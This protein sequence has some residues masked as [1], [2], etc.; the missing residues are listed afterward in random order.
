MNR[1]ATA[2][3][4]G[5]C[6]P[7]IACHPPLPTRI[8]VLGDVP[9]VIVQTLDTRI[10]NNYNVGLEGA[11]WSQQRVTEIHPCAAPQVS[12]QY[13]GNWDSDAGN[14]QMQV[15]WGSIFVN[16]TTVKPAGWSITNMQY[17]T[18]SFVMQAATRCV[19]LML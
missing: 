18:M 6:P 13:S 1:R 19:R 15:L 12:F 16:V 17:K 8:D 4:E 10:G 5:S 14:K 9:G 3:L 2:P 11:V 7:A